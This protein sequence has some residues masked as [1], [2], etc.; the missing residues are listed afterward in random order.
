MT[1]KHLLLSC[2]MAACMGGSAFAKDLNSVGLSLGSLSNPYFNVLVE[3]ATAKAREINPNV[4]VTAVSSEYDLGKQFTQIDNFIAAGV[5]LILVAAADPHAIASAV[6]R[7]Q[8]A[9]IVVVAVDVEAEGADATV[10][11]DNTLAG[12]LSCQYL[13]EKLVDGGKVAI[14]W[15]GP[16]SS[17][18]A[19]VE[20]CKKVLAQHPGIEVLDDIQDSKCQRDAGMNVMLAHLQ[21]YPDLKGL[22]AICEPPAIGANL[23]AKQLHRSGIV[24]T[25]VDGSP[26]A[27]EALKSET[28]LEGTATQ[29]PRE[30]GRLGVEVGYDLLNG[31][32]PEAK[33]Q[34]LPPHLVTRD[35]VGQYNGW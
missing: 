31:K 27:A 5:D 9:G 17:S 10:Q 6:K 14:Q 26:D 32:Q 19:R 16:T 4:R 22:F 30:Q 20:G 7:A 28:L 1:Y 18:I 13:A 2:A 3:G 25:S 34:L 35:N 21:R 8:A 23:A 11:T 12:E 15:A 29:N 33:V 24:I